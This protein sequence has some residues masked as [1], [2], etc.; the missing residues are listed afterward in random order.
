MSV[1]KMYLALAGSTWQWAAG[2]RS[3]AQGLSV[4]CS[5]GGSVVMVLVALAVEFRTSPKSPP[6]GLAPPTLDFL[7]S[8]KQERHHET[9]LTAPAEKTFKFTFKTTQGLSWPSSLHM[10]VCT[11]VLRVS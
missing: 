7:K 3:A 11:L 10:D 6:A 9:T 2:H 4:I 8:V 5:G 1:V